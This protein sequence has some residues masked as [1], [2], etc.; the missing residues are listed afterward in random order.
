MADNQHFTVQMLTMI[1][2]MIASVLASSGFWM[3]MM[4]RQEKN[5]NRTK[6]L[7]GLAHD[8]IVYLGMC[9]INRGWINRDEYE[10]L[11][12]YLAKPYFEMGGNGTAHRV[13]IEI[14][15]LPIEQKPDKEI[16]KC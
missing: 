13:M 10:N 1:I 14:E 11:H 4:K 2:T 9:Y 6:L 16:P 12:E 3:Y 5:D 15:K 7:M 8:R